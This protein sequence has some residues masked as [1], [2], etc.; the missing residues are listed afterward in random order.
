MEILHNTKP[1]LVTVTG[2]V[3]GHQKAD[4]FKILSLE[5]LHPEKTDLKEFILNKNHDGAI[6]AK[7]GVSYEVTDIRVLE[8]VQLNAVKVAIALNCGITDN[9]VCENCTQ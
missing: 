6:C 4:G 7:T 8:P 1:C 3:S 9:L 2:R 5:C